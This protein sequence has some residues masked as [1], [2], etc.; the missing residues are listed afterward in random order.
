MTKQQML[1][2]IE[3]NELNFD[4]VRKYIETGRLKNFAELF[5]QHQVQ[6][7]TSETDYKS[8]E[9]W[10]QW[11]TA[12][13][14]KSLAEHGVFRLGDIIGSANEQIWEHLEKKGISVGAISPMNAENRLKNPAYFVPDP[15]TR[16]KVN[17]GWILSKLYDS[18]AQA[19]NDNASSKITPQS[20]FFLLLGAA[21]YA[22][23]RNYLRYLKLALGS[24]SKKWNQALF[25]DLLLADC[26]N[27]L[28]SKH[29]P[30]FATL[31][32]NA[33]AHVQHH[34]MFSSAFSVSP[35]RNPS[36]YVADGIDPIFEVYDLYDHI[37]GQVMG[38]FPE[39]RLLLMT[40]LHQTTYPKISY[41]WRLKNHEVFLKSLGLKFSSI[42]PLMSRDFL[43]KC[44]NEIE[45]AEFKDE[46]EAIKTPDGDNLF[47][48]D[49]RID[50]VF[51]ELTYDHDIQEN[52]KF[53]NKGQTF[54]NMFENVAFVAIK[55]GEH[56]GVGYY[57]DTKN[58]INKD[59]ELT[60]PL[61]DVFH[62]IDKAF[63]A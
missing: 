61:R 1:L 39:A 30:Q 28:Q 14:G 31:F 62:M 63:Q 53:V 22:S 17:G 41:Y 10:I 18:I 32:L 4:Y 20:I 60:F 33:G 7:T 59:Q 56:T 35:H 29:K 58:P 51:V 54:S 52:F 42:V 6:Q 12:H 11:V 48:C 13:T 36:W 38:R 46:L 45:A 16:S 57:L 2:T 15:W 44:S 5:S 8:L 34:Y 55:N 23:P 21:R 25:L 43:V 9:P 49:K 50:D 3:L 27:S 19:V 37:L 26:F 40:G 47:T 24:K